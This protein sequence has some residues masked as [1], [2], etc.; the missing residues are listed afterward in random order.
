MLQ[1]P[2]EQVLL[3]LLELHLPLQV[4]Q[5]LSDLLVPSEQGLQVPQELRL[6]LQVLQVAPVPR[7]P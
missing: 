4:L 5:V 2:S 1:V 7:A 3:A 6:P